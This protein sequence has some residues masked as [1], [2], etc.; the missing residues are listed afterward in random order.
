MQFSDPDAAARAAIDFYNTDFNANKDQNQPVTISKYPDAHAQWRPGTPSIRSFVAHGPYVLSV[1]ALTPSPDLTGLT[2]LTEK[3]LDTQ[4]P[5]LDTLKQ[6]SDEET[7]TLPWDPDYLLSR[8]LN[9]VGSG[10]PQFGDDNGVFGPH[11]ITHYML[12]RKQAAQSVAALKADEF[13]K[14][15]DALV[16]RTADAASAKKAVTDRITLQGGGPAVAPVPEVPDSACVEN[17]TK[18]VKSTAPQRYICI[19]A[20]RNY[21]GY[22]TSRQLLDV[23]QRAA[24]QYALFANSQW[25]P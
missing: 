7:L 19:V 10:R 9:T 2:A 6:I 22:V 24:A 8:A 11:A 16:A 23:H 3:T 15:S 12:D 14:T 21:V 5:L 18:S 20:Y 25:Q 4:L 1:L 17:T 13:A